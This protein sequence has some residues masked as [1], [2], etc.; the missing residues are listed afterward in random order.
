LSTSIS[1]DR[2][3][4]LQRTLTRLGTMTANPRAVL[5]LAVFGVSWL[6]FEPETFDGPPH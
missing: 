1:G 2:V 4:T 3:T 6:V 5:V